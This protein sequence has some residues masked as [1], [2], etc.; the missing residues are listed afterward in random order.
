MIL[1]INPRI[2]VYP[3]MTKIKGYLSHNLREEF[4][5]LKSKLPCLWTNASFISTVGSVALEEIQKYI[6]EQKKN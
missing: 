6:E 2:G 4:P 1:D 3:T 5:E